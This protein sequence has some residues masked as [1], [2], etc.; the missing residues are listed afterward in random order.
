M[1]IVTIGELLVD[2]TQTGE[3]NNIPQYAA[4]PGGAPAN[5]AVAASLMGSNTAFIGKVGADSF[6]EMLADTLKN[7]NV[8]IDSIIVSSD[9]NTTLAVVSHDE[10]GERSFSFYRKN[11]ADVNLREDELPVQVI[12]SADIFHF[13][14]VSLTDEP[15]KS[16]IKSAVKLAKSHGSIITYDPNYRPL[17]WD[18]E[19]AA[20]E[21]MK[22]LL[23]LVDII[24]VSEEELYLLTDTESIPDGADKLLN[25]GI[26]IVIV[27]LGENGAFY[28]TPFS[29]GKS[30]AFTGKVADTNGAGDTFFGAFLSQ[31][32]DFESF[33]HNK[34]SVLCDA[35]RFAC[36][37]AGLSVRKS[38][39]IPSM[40]TKQE[41]E[42]F[43][44]SCSK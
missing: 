14:S 17:L 3:I 32:D 40:P 42:A 15:C 31:I 6:G 23:P 37:A 2:L 36:A 10:K 44:A 33:V 27:T 13:G 41:T 34:N 39:A 19:D 16:A 43:I 38:G 5:V 28:K 1:K 24:K 18:D 22:E 29:Q 26:S 12:E 20:K 9:F 11:C 30:D 25:E 7:K 21:A 4:H 8:D 35:V